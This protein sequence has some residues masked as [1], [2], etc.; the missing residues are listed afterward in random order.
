MRGYFADELLLITP[1]ST[2]PGVCLFGEVIGTHKGPLAIALAEQSLRTQEIT[3]DLTGVHYL[4]NSALEILVALANNL[5]PPQCLLVRAPTALGLR[6][7]VAARGW[8]RM[9]TLRL[10]EI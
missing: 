10:I 3:V 7:R 6:E 4:A 8:D 5:R 2:T 9:E 1:S